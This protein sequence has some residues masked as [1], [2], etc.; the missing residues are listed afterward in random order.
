MDSRGAPLSIVGLA[1]V[2][3]ALA[4]FTFGRA[5]QLPARRAPLEPAWRDAAEAFGRSPVWRDGKAEVAHYAATRTVYGKPR[6]HEA[7]LITVGEDLDT[8]TYT[9]ADPPYRTKTLIAALKLNVIATIPTENYPYHYMTSVFVEQADPTR[10]LKLAQSSQEWCGTTFKEVT[11]FASR[12]ALR[13]HSYWGGQGDGE[14]ELP[15]PAG[16]LLED[17][18]PVSLRALPFAAGFRRPVRL[19]RSLADTK[20]NPPVVLDAV[21]AVE[22]PEAAP[23]VGRAW[24]VTVSGKG[25]SLAYWMGEAA[26]HVLARFD[27]GD[28]RTLELKSVSRRTYW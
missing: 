6:A 19:V 3:L 16:T 1:L 26:P 24:K 17:Q 28:G 14:H 20:A 9:K 11:G 4:A 23:V 10:L 8:A 25:A 27:G 2:L 21:L 7:V 12:P 13:Y 22:G 15:L 18:L 5:A